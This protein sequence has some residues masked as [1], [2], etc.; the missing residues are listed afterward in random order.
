MGVTTKE[1]GLQEL[2]FADVN[3]SCPLCGYII[4]ADEI[5]PP[6]FNFDGVAGKGEVHIHFSGEC[7]KCEKALSYM[8]VFDF[9]EDG[10]F[11][12]PRIDLY[13]LEISPNPTKADQEYMAAS[14]TP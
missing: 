4:Y 8:L 2:Y 11:S 1:Q 12:M 14:V 7:E 9:E 3:A 5:V 6:G 10:P 13:S